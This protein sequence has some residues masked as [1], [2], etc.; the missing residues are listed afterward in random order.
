MQL[1]VLYGTLGCHLCEQ[2]EA[3]L[4]P[5]FDDTCQIE[6]I[7]ISEDD[8]LLSRYALSIPVLRRLHDHAELKWPFNSEQA[9]EFLGC[10]VI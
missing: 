4:A 10:S 1:F 2:A 9:R 7:D 6:C 5:L 8:A 3:L